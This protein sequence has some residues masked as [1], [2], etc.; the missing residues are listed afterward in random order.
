[1]F[2]CLEFVYDGVKVDTQFLEIRIFSFMYGEY[3]KHRSFVER[4]EI[5]IRTAFYKSKIAFLNRQQRRQW[6]GV[7]IIDDRNF[8]DR[9]PDIPRFVEGIIPCLIT[10]E[11][12]R[13]R[14][15][16]GI[17]LSRDPSEEIAVW[18]VTYYLK[19]PLFSR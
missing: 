17:V 16:L 3:E 5:D 10:S 12:R 7:P 6:K 18:Y 9:S 1:M 13:I 8:N 14:L 15:S 4:I 2:V 11:I 19:L